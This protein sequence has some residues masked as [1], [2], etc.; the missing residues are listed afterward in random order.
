MPDTPAGNL[1]K[2]R[3][4]P[5]VVVLRCSVVE[6][7]QE[8]LVQAL[9]VAIEQFLRV[10][11]F[12]AHHLRKVDDGDVGGLRVD[13]DVKLV[14]V[15]VHETVP[16]QVLQLVH[17]LPVHIRHAV[18]EPTGPD[19]RQRGSVHDGHEHRVSVDVDGDGHGE[20]VIAERLH[21]RVLL[22]RGEPGEVQPAG[23]R[24]GL[25]DVVALGLD[26]PEGGSTEAMELERESLAF[27]GDDLVDVG[28]LPDADAPPDAVD[29][30]AVDERLDGEVV[31]PE[32]REAVGVVLAVVVM[33]ELVLEQLA[34][35]LVRA[36]VLQPRDGVDELHGDELVVLH[37]HLHRDEDAP[38]VLLDV[39]E[40]V[41][42]ELHLR[43]V[44]GWRRRALGVGPS[45]PAPSEPL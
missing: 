5:P 40:H 28:F 4:L 12:G 31:V 42:V 37:A 7:S 41:D 32:R 33:H 19:L 13:H 16:R 10:W 11:V 6:P 43:F 2:H 24:G 3:I 36:S 20:A 30:A 22:Q 17:A 21:E 23:V 34:D 18:L 27:F 39:A 35:E 45:V 15:A 14:V 9:Q 29:G 8:E 25:L 44:G 26:R 38:G 1:E